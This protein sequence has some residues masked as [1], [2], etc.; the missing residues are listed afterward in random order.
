MGW[1]VHRALAFSLAM[2]VACAAAL[3]P[4]LTAFGESAVPDSA[5]LH[6]DLSTM[7]ENSGFRAGLAEP[8]MV[9]EH[10][11]ARRGDC[12]I[13]VSDAQVGGSDIARFGQKTEKV[14][15]TRFRYN[16]SWSDGLPRLRP[17][18]ENSAQH[19]LWKLGIDY[20]YRPVLM[21]AASKGCK[22]EEIPWTDVLLYPVGIRSLPKATPFNE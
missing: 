7:L 22:L 8:G 9:A 15:P 2:G 3:G 19:H 20:G 6:R 14:G 16:G 13:A 12:R 10:V 21:I 1:P 5:R 17:Y 11:I 4:K 18:V